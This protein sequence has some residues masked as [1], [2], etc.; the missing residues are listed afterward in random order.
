MFI[1]IAA[2]G[3]TGRLET[4]MNIITKEVFIKTWKYPVSTTSLA[5]VGIARTVNKMVAR[6]DI[7]DWHC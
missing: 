4:Q 6:A 5:V 3:G 2:A 1:T 7:L